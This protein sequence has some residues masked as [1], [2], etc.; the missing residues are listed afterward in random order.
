MTDFLEANGQF[1]PVAAITKIYASPTEGGAVFVHCGGSAVELPLVLNHALNDKPGDA[2][3]ATER[4]ALRAVREL[5][6]VLNHVEAQPTG[7]QQGAHVISYAGTAKRPVDP[8]GNHWRIERLPL[9][10]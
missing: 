3:R 1:I 10:R 8:T 4:E 7:T 6:Q 5:L 2:Y 9:L